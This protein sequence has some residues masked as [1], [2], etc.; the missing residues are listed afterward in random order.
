MISSSLYNS[1]TITS[2]MLQVQLHRKS[3]LHFSVMA[4]ANKNMPIPTLQRVCTCICRSCPIWYR[5]YRVGP[6]VSEV[7]IHHHLAGTK[8]KPHFGSNSNFYG[9]LPTYP[10]RNP[11]KW[12]NTT[13]L[14]SFGFL[15]WPSHR[16]RRHFIWQVLT[17]MCHLICLKA[18][19]ALDYESSC[20][21]HQW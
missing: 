11:S 7:Q 17:A 14:R 2:Y 21:I 1:I 18:N 15:F 16:F 10:C 13:L 3:I 19:Q 9:P 20:W 12:R 8:R 5:A 6:E 4:F